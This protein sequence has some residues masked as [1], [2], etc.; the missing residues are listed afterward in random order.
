MY[1][2]PD[3]YRGSRVTCKGD[4]RITPFGC[5]LRDTKINELPQLWNV[6][7][8][9]MSLVGPRPEDVIIGNDW[10]K[11]A[12]QEIL[13]VRP[14]ITSPASILYQDEETLLSKANIMEDYFKNIL[15]DKIRLDR[16]YVR[17][18]SFGSDLDIIFWTLL[19]IVPRIIKKKIPESYLFSGP[20]T[21]LINRYATWFL[22]DIVTSLFVI[23]MVSVLWRIQSPLNWGM[24]RLLILAIVLTF[25]FSGVNSIFGLNRIEWS[26]ATINDAIALAISCWFVTFILGCLTTL[27]A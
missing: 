18:R 12:R 3:S 6:L 9:D 25:V 27:F 13:S 21:R 10:D 16:L 4:D 8:G 17:N 11:E 26:S 20:F 22:F 14:G 1:E 23:V 24:D 5:W 7:K 2:T 19:I 15:P